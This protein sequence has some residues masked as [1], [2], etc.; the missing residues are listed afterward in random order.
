[1]TDAF[2]T[3]PP[4]GETSSTV[5]ADLVGEDKKFKTNELLAVGKQ[6]A[7][8]FI[9]KLQDEN[10]QALAALEEAQGKG[11]DSATVSELLKAVQE[12]QNKD[13]PK[14]TTPQLSEEALVDLVKKTLQGENAS[15]TAE[16][17]RKEANELVLQKVGGDA[18]AAKTYVAERAK[19]LGISPERL[20]ELSEESPSAFA[21]LVGLTTKPSSTKSITDLPGAKNTQA[22][23][24]D[25]IQEIEGHKTKAHYSAIRKEMGTL[26]FLSNKPIQIQMLKDAMAL[27]TERFNS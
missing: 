27:G 9:V 10:K 1:M 24:A 25:T 19:A 22:F 26:K 17:N 16:A 4:T 12:A 8:A 2:S 14:D 20:G 11:K 3:T 18:E 23:T 21:T 5:L 6:E 15:A 7:D 13:T